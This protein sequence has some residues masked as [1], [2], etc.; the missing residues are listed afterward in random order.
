VNEIVI[1]FN[2]L[3][4]DTRLITSQIDTSFV[5]VCVCVCVC[6]KIKIKQL[7]NSSE[8]SRDNT[9]DRKDNNWRAEIIHSL[10]IRQQE[11]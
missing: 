5:C 6:K 3:L 7:W 2:Y 1:I 9:T 4:L 11:V 8:N 10:I